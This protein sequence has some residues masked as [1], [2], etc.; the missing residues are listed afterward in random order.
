MPRNSSPN[1]LLTH[2]H[3]CC[4]VTYDF[5]E[6]IKE[7]LISENIIQC[8]LY[9]WYFLITLFE[10]ISR[11][12]ILPECHPHK[13]NTHSKTQPMTSLLGRVFTQNSNYNTC[14]LQSYS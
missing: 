11:N 5:L 13:M 4:F 2:C 9:S 12:G 1:S 8:I 10:N 14:S 3:A 7:S 6:C